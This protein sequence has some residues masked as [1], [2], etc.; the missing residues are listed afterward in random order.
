MWNCQILE[1]DGRLKLSFV[2]YSQP[3]LQGQRG[4]SLSSERM[5]Q[6]RFAWNNFYQW[7]IWAYPLEQR[8]LDTSDSSRSN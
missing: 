4:T 2:N 8:P 1:T 6:T 3:D 5:S 7:A